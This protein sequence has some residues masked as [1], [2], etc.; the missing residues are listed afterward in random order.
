[1]RLDLQDYARCPRLADGACGAR[2]SN[3]ED[4]PP[5]WLPIC[6]ISRTPRRWKKSPEVT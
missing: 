5:V 6:R 2:F 1:M 4:C 3:G